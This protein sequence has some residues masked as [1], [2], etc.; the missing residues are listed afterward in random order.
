MADGTEEASPACAVR[1]VLASAQGPPAMHEAP[2]CPRMGGV[3]GP[4]GCP[5]GCIPYDL[6]YTSLLK[7][8]FLYQ[9]ARP[10]P[11]PSYLSVSQM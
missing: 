3:G 11:R 10:F 5:A 1:L 9:G 4:A 8:D 6:I 2:G 7:T